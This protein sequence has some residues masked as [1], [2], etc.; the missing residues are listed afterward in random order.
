MIKNKYNR[1]NNRLQNFFRDIGDHNSAGF[2]RAE[3]GSGEN[4]NDSDG[5]VELFGKR[6]DA[7]NALGG[8][9]CRESDRSR[10][11]NDSDE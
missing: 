6:G 11:A 7:P 5:L 10:D 3:D 2:D 4:A 8:S 1:S 9:T